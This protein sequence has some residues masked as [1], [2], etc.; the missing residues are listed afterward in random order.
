MAYHP[1]HATRSH[2]PAVFAVRV[3]LGIAAAAF[4]AVLAN[5]VM[6]LLAMAGSGSSASGPLQLSD[7]RPLTFVGIVAG[8]AGLAY[9]VHRL[10]RR[11]GTAT[12]PAPN[13]P[14]GPG[15]AVPS[16]DP[17]RHPRQWF[18]GQHVDDRAFSHHHRAR[19]GQP[20]RKG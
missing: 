19:A 1:T 18:D 6:T 3:A 17:R 8:L 12:P 10:G 5:L 14:T 9:V 7:N 15:V 4:G 11:N 13:R 16:I 20:R 2:R